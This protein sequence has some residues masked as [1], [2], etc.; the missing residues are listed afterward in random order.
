MTTISDL[1]KFID[2][3]EVVVRYNIKKPEKSYLIRS[4]IIPTLIILVTG[5]AVIFLKTHH[6]EVLKEFV[7]SHF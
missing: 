6:I 1:F 3:S 4:S 2:G 5:V 7:L